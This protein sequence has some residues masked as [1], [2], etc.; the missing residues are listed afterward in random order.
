ME[1]KS[2]KIGALALSALCG[3]AAL[4][5]EARQE[6][7]ERLGENGVSAPALRVE[8]GSVLQFVNAD[9][10]PHQV[11][12]NDCGELSSTLL[13]PG[14]TYAVEIGTGPKTCHFQDL[15]APLATAYAGTVEV[16]DEQEERR[17][18]TGD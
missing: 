8:A 6:P 18:A 11:Y 2:M 3:C 13:R 12:S 9:A 1:R 10:R 4:R 16:H 5:R 15:L 14:E 7:I 17:R